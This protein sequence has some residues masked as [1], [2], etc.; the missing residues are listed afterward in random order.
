MRDKYKD[1]TIIILYGIILLTLLM[2]FFV[3]GSTKDWLNQHIVFPEYFRDIFYST[4]KLLPEFSFN[5]GA[6]QNMFNLAYYGLMSPIILLSYLLP[7]ISMKVFIIIAGIILYLLSGIF[8]YKFIDNNFHN[9]KYSL[10]SGLLYMTLP[11]LTYHFHHHIMFVFYIPFLILSL[12]EV[13][14][15]IDNNRSFKLM[16]FILIIILINYYYSVGALITIFIYYIYKLLLHNKFNFKYLF[17]MI[18]IFIIPIMISSFLLL[19]VGYTILNAH[20]FINNASQ[21][22]NLINL[23]VINFKELFYSTFSL[24]LS[25]IFFIA[26]FGNIYNKHK[27]VSNYF[28]N[29]SLLVLLIPIFMYI[30]NGMLY[31]RGKSLIPFSIL[32]IYSF[33]LFIKNI[34]SIDY[35]KLN[36]TIIISLII[37]FIFNI[38]SISYI[39]EILFVGYLLEKYIHDKKKYKKLFFG[40]VLFISLFFSFYFNYYGENHITYNFNNKYNIDNKSIDKLLSNID[41]K[42]RVDI[43]YNSRDLVNKIYNDKHLSNSMY[44]STYNY[45]YFYIYNNFF[46]IIL[47]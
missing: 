38:K 34:K 8:M 24:G 1:Y 23:F 37:I 31:I 4:G 18:S 39:L 30:L 10:Y 28:L 14:N 21:E 3:F 2:G 13:D 5:L 25:G 6:G 40:Y 46:N 12:I 29:I 33:I 43:I 17:R 26:L 7:F 11:I 42:Y 45:D 22:V 19:P 9:R 44:S 41:N 47:F 20:R 27:S 16:L 32:Y 36:K 15:Y 35:I